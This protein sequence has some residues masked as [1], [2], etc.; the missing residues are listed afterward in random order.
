[1]K[2]SYKPSGVCVKEIKLE[3][4]DN[5]LKSVEFVGGCPGNL[6]LLKKLIEG[7][8]IDDIMDSISLPLVGLIPSDDELVLYS[9]KGTPV[10]STKSLCAAPVMNIAQRIS[11]VSTPLAKLWRK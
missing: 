2:M 3:V 7:K 6:A 8:N 11:G 9:N 5:I 1:M 10:V 4:E